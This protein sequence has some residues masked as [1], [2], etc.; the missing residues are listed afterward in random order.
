VAIGYLQLCEHV[1]TYDPLKSPSLATYAWKAM[2]H[3]MVRSDKPAGW[4]GWEGRETA[5]DF[6]AGLCEEDGDRDETDEAITRR[7]DDLCHGTVVATVSELTANAQRAPGE[8]GIVQRKS[9]AHAIQA[10]ETGRSTL[11]ER[12][13]TVIDMRHR[14]EPLEFEAMAQALGKNERTVRRWYRQAFER[15]SARVRARVTEPPPLEG[16]PEEP[17]GNGLPGW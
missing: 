9:Y 7:I 8:E 3:A 10:L 11:V 4:R 12:E 15:L 2:Y 5:C 16:R 14:E 13:A 17:E 6:L 1:R